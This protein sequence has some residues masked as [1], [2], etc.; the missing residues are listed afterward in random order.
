MDKTAIRV[1]DLSLEELFEVRKELEVQAAYLERENRTYRRECQ[2]QVPDA[3]ANLTEV[4]AE[5]AAVFGILASVCA[6]I[7]FLR[8]EAKT[9]EFA[10]TAD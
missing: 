9:A 1:S 7:N 6:K 10:I 5:Q 4:R 2:Q 8:D 3:Y